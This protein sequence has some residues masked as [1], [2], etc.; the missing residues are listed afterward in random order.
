MI[1]YSYV[2]FYQRVNPAVDRKSKDCV[3]ERLNPRLRLSHFRIHLRICKERSTGH[4]NALYVFGVKSHGCLQMFQFNQPIDHHICDWLPMLSVDLFILFIFDVCLML[5]FDPYI[6]PTK[7]IHWINHYSTTYIIYSIYIF[8][9][10]PVVTIDSMLMIH[11]YP[12]T[13]ST[14]IAVTIPHYIQFCFPKYCISVYIY[15]CILI[16]ISSN[17]IVFAGSIFA[18]FVMVISTNQL[19][20]VV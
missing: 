2:S 13:C 10:Y 11:V 4:P 20:Q 7:P 6:F 14:S 1:F 18:Y 19:I 16:Y 8:H 9:F 5:K 17:H 3:S 15:I 12:L